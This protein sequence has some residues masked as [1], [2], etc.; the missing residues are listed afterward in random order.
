MLLVQE[1][2]LLLLDEPV[3]GMT[4]RERDATGHLLRA[5]GQHRTVLVIEHDM[6]FV[7]EFASRVT[8]LHQGRVLSEG[9]VEEVQRD[10]RVIDV[11]LGRGREHAE[12]VRAA[13][14]AEAP[15]APRRS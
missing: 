10:P 4:R 5:I 9:P 3:A 8:V 15:P 11:Y 14:A 7:R 6:A 2:R 1:P 13:V 12:E